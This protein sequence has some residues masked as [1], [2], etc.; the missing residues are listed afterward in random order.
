MSHETLEEIRIP[1]LIYTRFGKE[2]IKVPFNGIIKN[3]AMQCWCQGEL[4]PIT[5]TDGKTV[6]SS[7]SEF[8]DE[9]EF[10]NPIQKK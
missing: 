4:F 9:R 10:F 6:G 8:S 3:G 1:Q 7:P 2:Y 5:N